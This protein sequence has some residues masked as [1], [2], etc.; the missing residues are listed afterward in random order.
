MTKKWLMIELHF[1]TYFVFGIQHRIKFELTSK[2]A[3]SHR[4]KTNLFFFSSIK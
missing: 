1:T 2:S 3:Y 4:R